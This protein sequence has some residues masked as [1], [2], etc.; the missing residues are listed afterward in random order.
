MDISSGKE[1]RPGQASETFKHKY[2]DP[3]LKR[4]FQ[5]ISSMAKL[6]RNRSW[7]KERNDWEADLTDEAGFTGLSAILFGLRMGGYV[8]VQ[9]GKSLNWNQEKILD[10][11]KN[12]PESLKKTHEQ[13]SNLIAISSIPAQSQFKLSDGTLCLFINDTESL[14]AIMTDSIFKPPQDCSRQSVV[15]IDCG[16]V[17]D[18][19]DLI[20]ITTDKAVYLIDCQVLDVETVYRKLE[21]FL[22]STL[23]VKMIHDLHKDAVALDRFGSIKLEGV[24]D[25]QLVAEHLWGEFLLVL[26][27][28]E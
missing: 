1:G 20:Q 4:M 24:L 17:P 9:G 23:V 10:A 14:E 16:G 28:C 8:K 7:P 5:A 12:M 3:S 26:R 6:Y 15:A 18:A 19:L 13:V 22:R 27:S 2:D 11:A 25:T 21:T